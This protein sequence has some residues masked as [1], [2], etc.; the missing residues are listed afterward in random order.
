M[1]INRLRIPKHYHQEAK[2]ASTLLLFGILVLLS[3][4]KPAFS[5]CYNSRGINK[6]REGKLAGAEADYLQALALDPDNAKALY[7]LGSLYEDLQ[8]FDQANA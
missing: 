4:N 8:Q 7:N 6:H 5:N 2:F 3:L 1:S